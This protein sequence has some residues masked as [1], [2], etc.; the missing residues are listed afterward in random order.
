MKKN[1]INKLFLCAAP[2]RGNVSLKRRM[3]R[4]ASRI[5]FRY[6]IAYEQGK[7]FPLLDCSHG[8]GKETYG[9]IKI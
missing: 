5:N 1:I 9:N 8:Y 2:C 7:L 3:R 4:A 6:S